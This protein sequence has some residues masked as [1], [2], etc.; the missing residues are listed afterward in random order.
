MLDDTYGF[1]VLGRT[2]R[3]TPEHFDMTTND[4]E[5]YAGAMST[6]LGSVGGFCAGSDIV[7]DHQRLAASGYVFSASLPPYCSIAASAALAILD[8]NPNLARQMQARAIQ[9]RSSMREQ[10]L[11]PN[12]EMVPCV[13]DASPLVHF[14]IKCAVVDVQRKSARGSK[15]PS[16]SEDEALQRVVETLQSDGIIATRSLFN[17]EES[18]DCRASLRLALK[19][20]LS[21]AEVDACVK[22]VAKAFIQVASNF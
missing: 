9:F 1:G 21:E 19:A 8:E 20:E 11:P 3:G 17:R 7:V 2:G 13:G 16:P 5:V 4:V 10:K 22:K 15:M 6:S 18:V 14:T 12:V